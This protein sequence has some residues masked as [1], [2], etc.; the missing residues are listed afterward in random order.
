MNLLADIYKYQLNVK[1]LS[2]WSIKLSGAQ[3][4]FF[5]KEDDKIIYK[6]C[7]LKRRGVKMAII[8]RIP[9]P[10]NITG[11]LNKINFSI[12][13]FKTMRE[14]NFLYVDKSKII[15]DL[16]SYDERKVI[17][18]TR[19]RRFGKSL[20]LSML[21]YFFD[22]TEDS[23]RLFHGLYIEHSNTFKKY[24]NRFPVLY[25]NFK[26]ITIGSTE[27]IEESLGDMFQDVIDELYKKYKF[28]ELK[29]LLI[30]G[31]TGS[32]RQDIGKRI[33][34]ILFE[35]TKRN[36]VVLIDEYDSLVNQTY[37]TKYWEKT[38][39]M[40]KR[41][42]GALFKSN[43]YLETGILTGVSR[44]GKELGFSDLNNMDVYGLTT[45]F[46]YEYFGF[47]EAEVHELLTRNQLKMQKS[48]YRMYNGYHFLNS[49]NMFNTVS[50]LK[51]LDN[52]YKT[53][54]LTLSPHWI[55]SSANAI[56]K[57]NIRQQNQEF[58]DQLLS[59]LD[60][61]T[62][63]ESIFECIDFGMLNK[64]AHMFSLLID[65]G[66]LCPVRKLDGNL[67]EIK[68]PNEEV[69]YGYQDMIDSIIGID[70]EILKSL[71]TYLMKAKS[72]QFEERFNKIL[73]SVSSYHDFSEKENSYHNLVLGILLYMLGRY[74]IKSNR[75][76]GLGRFDIAMIPS[77]A[78]KNKYCPIIIEFKVAIESAREKEYSAKELLGLADKAL[79]QIEEKQYYMAY[80]D[81]Y[82]K[83]SFLFLGI[84]I[85]GKRCKVSSKK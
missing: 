73:L 60:G 22:M 68:V 18:F 4:L 10:L 46:Y 32:L 82:S 16:F 31:K 38:T 40:V 83:E 6:I 39:D 59:L 78:F 17:L 67:F 52:Y 28:E 11:N 36:V 1:E 21:R 58:K 27:D 56:L 45:D 57:H 2:N 77:T 69:L 71:C 23:K 51:F 66:Y 9:N 64:P 47:T 43:L 29:Q 62:M 5:L 44:I 13:D 35:K 50:M 42:L 20:N 48:F 70:G 8:T 85:Q 84:G 15:E 49:P 19:P 55:N 81:Q 74:Q 25:L 63:E 33:T 26:D 41:I 65:T 30:Y 54:D 24:S 37:G 76:S 7:V 34:R 72:A 61:S 14:G 3:P 80:A 53:G 12:D 79:K 75:E